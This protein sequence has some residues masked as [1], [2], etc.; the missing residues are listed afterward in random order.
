[1]CC[2]VGGHSP[3]EIF[4]HPGALLYAKKD[5]RFF[6]E[7]VTFLSI[8]YTSIPPSWLIK[9]NT[10]LWYSI[11]KGYYFRQHWSL[12]NQTML[13]CQDHDNI[14]MKTQAT[15]QATR[16]CL[17]GWSKSWCHSIAYDHTQDEALTCSLLSDQWSLHSGEG[18]LHLFYINVVAAQSER[19]VST[20][21]V[22]K[23]TS[24]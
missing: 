20:P 9:Y 18:R 19:H 21:L 6:F 17:P 14:V 23:L 8:M 7:V 1:M 5:C 24:R 2:S 15:R 11:W 13:I 4:L 16:T 22:K 12:K 10:R 3:T